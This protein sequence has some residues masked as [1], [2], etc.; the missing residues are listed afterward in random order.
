MRLSSL[1]TDLLSIVCVLKGLASCNSSLLALRCSLQ[2]VS[3]SAH[4]TV[5]VW[6][7][8]G[9]SHRQ[10]SFSLWCAS[11]RFHQIH[12]RWWQQHG[13]KFLVLRIYFYL[14][15]PVCVVQSCLL[16]VLKPRHFM[17][18]AHLKDESRA[19]WYAAPDS[20]SFTEGLSV[21]I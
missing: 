16:V 11:G 19:A 20:G 6:G 15:F 12:Y 9:F 10:S 17:L 21:V 2:C 18:W 3:P 1:M 4:S 13:L 8:L 7:H 5:S 14:W